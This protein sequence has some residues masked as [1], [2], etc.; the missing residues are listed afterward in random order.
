MNRY[1]DLI[2]TALSDVNLN[3]KVP[4]Q[5]QLAWNSLNVPR[6]GIAKLIFFCLSMFLILLANCLFFKG[7]TRGYLSAPFEETGRVCI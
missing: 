2:D 4:S 1:N 6:E 3:K 5:L 7:I